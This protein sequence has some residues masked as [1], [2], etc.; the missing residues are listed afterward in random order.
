MRSFLLLLAVAVAA[1]VEA[2]A[3]TASSR[4]SL[5]TLLHSPNNRNK[6]GRHP[7]PRHRLPGRGPVDSGDP[8]RLHRRR[9]FETCPDP[10]YGPNA[11]SAD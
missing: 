3:G 7:L 8:P 11:L 2:S 5:P 4:P 10:R 6:F 9:P 1:V